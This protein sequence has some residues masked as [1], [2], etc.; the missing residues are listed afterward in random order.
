M[1]TPPRYSRAHRCM[2]A[3]ATNGLG[4]RWRRAREPGSPA[5]L[6]GALFG[7]AEE[8]GDAHEP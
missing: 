2:L 1:A 7:Y 6:I 3:G 8:F 5:E 4:C